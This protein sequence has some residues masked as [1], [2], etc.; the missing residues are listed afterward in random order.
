[1]QLAHIS[2]SPDRSSSS[3]CEH[4][5]LADGGLSSSSAYFERSTGQA[6]QGNG[7]EALRGTSLSSFVGGAGHLSAVNDEHDGAEGANVPLAL[8]VLI[9]C[10]PLVV[11][12]ISFVQN[13]STWGAV[14]SV[15]AVFALTPML[16]LWIWPA[17]RAHVLSALQRQPCGLRTQLSVGLALGLGSFVG[18]ACLFEL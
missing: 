7:R 13:R 10:L 1:M 5:S 3:E 2:H 17:P 15:E 9:G 12:H 16:V 6:R 4:E 18:A 11:V 8:A 14:L